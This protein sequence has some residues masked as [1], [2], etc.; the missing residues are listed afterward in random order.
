MRNT[1]LIFVKIYLAAR[2]RDKKMMRLGN[3]ALNKVIVNDDFPSILKRTIL[4]K[5]IAMRTI[6]FSR[7]C[8][9]ALMCAY[10]MYP[11]YRLLHQRI[12]R[13]SAAY[14]GTTTKNI[15]ATHDG[16]CIAISFRTAFYFG[17]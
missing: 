12:S 9:R 15:I 6:T 17:K 13:Q 14:Q 2:N 5:T 4:M 11:F 3:K 16:P 7:N 8:T 1:I 10:S